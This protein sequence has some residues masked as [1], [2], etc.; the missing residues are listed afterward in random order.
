MTQVADA[1]LVLLD[2]RIT[3]L[4]LQP[5]VPA[6]VGALAVRSGRVLAAGSDDEVRQHV[7]PATRVVELG[8]RRVVPGLV[9]SHVHFV[10]AGRTWADEVRWE[11]MA[12][13]QD[14]LAAVAERAAQLE[15]GAWIRVIGGWSEDQF[16]ERRGP[17]REDLDAVAPDNPVFVQALYE[18]GVFNSAGIAALRLDEA[19]IAASPT[20]DQFERDADGAWNGR[21]TG[22]MAQ[23][24]WFYNQLPPP[25]FEREVVSTGLLSR[26]F[27]RLGL[28]GATDGGGVNSGPD[29]YGAVHEAW[30][31]G[32]LRTRVRMLKHA[33]RR[34]T[35]T[36]DF[37][38]Y[39][40]FGEP[41]FGDAM[42]RWSG[43]GEIIL[44]RSHDD[45]GKPADFSPEALAAAKE[46]LLPFARRGWAVQVHVMNREFLDGLLDLF[47]D[48]H[49]EVPI[50]TLRWAVIHAN[51]VTAGDVPRLQA[52]G[53]GVLHQA[54]LR[55][56]G[57]ALIAAWGAERVAGSPAL[58]ALLDA[59]VPVGLGSDGMR[60]SSYNPWASLQHFITGLTVGGTPTLTG[61]H[62]LSREEALAGYSR[63]TAWFTSEEH[64]RGQLTPGFLADL[65]V[66]SEDYF[67]VPVER[68]HTITSE[69]TLLGGDVVWSSGAVVPPT[70]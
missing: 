25:P 36:E 38:G 45:L 65:A 61:E 31:R 46:I 55:L 4:S 33:T 26:E 56:N 3:T 30:R 57:E 10:R 16:A 27:A 35:E 37:A 49:A 1:D 21:G 58:R 70:D 59:G 50:D 44:Y 6:E 34:G 28:V 9:D 24:S 19:T 43:I 60:A 63:D 51:A 14:A 5:G 39:L 42:L 32:L 52:L 12:S 18:Y 17:T 13:L 62:L 48:I 47:E 67:E 53:L 22:R 68:M 66:L 11:S 15:P 41:R 20:P 29:V 54:L 69:L 7:G 2:G 8:G 40:R 23:L 64:E